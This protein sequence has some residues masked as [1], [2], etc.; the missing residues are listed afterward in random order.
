MQTRIETEFKPPLA[1]IRFVSDPAGKPPAI[2]YTVLDELEAA[3]NTV[4][5]AA[6]E[7]RVLTVESAEVKYFVVGANLKALQEVD[8]VSIRP[9]VRRG[10]EVFAQL[11]EIEIPTV[12]LV[13]GFAGGGG[14]ELAL[15]CDMIFAADNARFALPEAGLGLVTGWG[16][17]YRLPARI[18]TPRA[19]EMAFSGRPVDA[20]RAYEM[21]LINFVG[22]EAEL[23]AKLEQFVADVA[24]NSAVSVAMEKGLINSFLGIPDSR[25]AFEEAAASTTAMSSSDTQQR[26]AAFFEARRKRAKEK[27]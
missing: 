22:P 17:S 21:G 1:K 18:G 5:D 26:L 13:R 4:R 23:Q 7:I 2:D 9:W 10:Q 14:L 12:A 27:G 11:Q 25:M 8:S 3:I 6:S 19:K 15:A 20:F 16:A 24:A